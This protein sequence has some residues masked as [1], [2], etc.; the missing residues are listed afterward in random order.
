MTQ[1][2][3]CAGQDRHLIAVNKII[4]EVRC[5]G[6]CCGRIEADDQ[7]IK[8]ESTFITLRLARIR[9][10]SCAAASLARPSLWVGAVSGVE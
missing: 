6:Q 1:D 3:Q 2:H 10:R 7:S 5:L 8:H 4:V 9:P